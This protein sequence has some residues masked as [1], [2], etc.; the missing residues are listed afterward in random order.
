MLKR[1]RFFLFLIT[2]F[3]TITIKAQQQFTA[4]Q[5][6]GDFKV[7]R[8]AVV[9]LSPVLN[10][11]ERKLLNEQLE[12]R[13]RALS[14]KSYT[15][16]QFLGFL[17]RTNFT[18]DK[19]GKFDGHA[20][21]NLSPELAQSTFATLKVFPFPIQLIGKEMLVNT[22][23]SAVAFGSTILSINGTSISSILNRI[24]T[25]LNDISW[26]TIQDQFGVFYQTIYGN[27]D[28]FEIEYK[29]PEGKLRRIELPGVRLFAPS[30]SFAAQVFPINIRG[31]EQVNYFIDSL[32]NTGFLQINSFDGD[33]KQMAAFM[34]NVF[35]DI[36]SN[37]LANL[38][39]DLRYNRGGDLFLPGLL[40]R[41]IATKSFEEEMTASLGG[42]DFPN[43]AYV[44]ALGYGSQVSTLPDSIKAHIASLKKDF[45]RRGDSWQSE[46]M[47][48]TVTQ[49]PLNAFKGKVYLLTSYETA[50]ASTY[51]A[52]L[53]K[54]YK[55]GAIIGRSVGGVFHKVT[56]GQ[57]INYQLPNT[58]IDVRIPLFA[59]RYAGD[60]LD[61]LSQDALV[62]DRLVTDAEYKSY[63][64][65][66]KDPEVEV[67]RQLLRPGQKVDKM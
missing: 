33:S 64:L 4:E 5:L 50:S 24:K 61:N 51:F 32:S 53:F 42:F 15:L 47:S 22:D 46:A 56:A 36:D 58:R 44:T 60:L 54:R 59:I 14:G 40:F 52:A 31:R 48:H 13:G 19:G 43:L 18:V 35:K 8:E 27:Q 37:K 26:S 10:L 65:Q 1:P 39:I 23:S 57:F 63:F 20:S 67:V 28:I 3:W 21:F 66:K 25:E 11:H 45:V 9:R 16:E 6:Q 49:A 2:A 41:H 17:S 30:R 55:R 62:P 29:S 38:V 7:I 34:E 12:E